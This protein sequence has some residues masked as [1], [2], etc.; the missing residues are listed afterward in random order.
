MNTKIIVATHKEKA[1]LNNEIF[2]PI[3]VNA[4]VNDYT[5]D[6]TYLSDSTLDN[7]SEKNYTFNELTALYWAWKN[8]KSPAIFGLMHYRRYLDINYK[9]KLFKKESQNILESVQ[10]NDSRLNKLL[11]TKKTEKNI[12]KHLKKYDFLVPRPAICS[13]NGIITSLENDYKHNHNPEDWD[14]CMDIIRK[15]FPDYD[16]SITK[17]LENGS[18]F[19]IGNMS[20]TRYELMN[21]YCNWLFTI[22]FETEQKITFSDDPY[23]RRVIGFLSER[24]FTLYILH[25]NFRLK[26]LPIL[27]VE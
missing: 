22:L 1:L 2:L 6:P 25:N 19:Y 18:N 20:I 11:D 10:K 13:I 15:K 7:I 27:F 5:I 24:L 8:L 17:Y 14:I 23:Q 21:D 4:K 26:H 16:E 9:K 3:Q 12:I